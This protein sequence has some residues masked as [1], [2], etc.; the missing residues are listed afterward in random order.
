MCTKRQREKAGRWY[1]R[2]FDIS[3]HSL[4]KHT[5]LVLQQRDLHQQ[6]HTHL[7]VHVNT[8][9]HE[10]LINLAGSF[11]KNQLQ[12]MTK[13]SFIYFYTKI[14]IKTIFWTEACRASWL[15]SLEKNKLVFSIQSIL[16]SLKLHNM[17]A[18]A[19]IPQLSQ[20]LWICSGLQA[21]SI[22]AKPTKTKALLLPLYRQHKL[23]NELGRKTRTGSVS[24][25]I[26]PQFLGSSG[27]EIVQVLHSY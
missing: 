4:R 23:V 10:Q 24:S 19:G 27:E 16:V 20:K 8:S 12:G 18:V 7:I 6:M 9:R 11:W 26:L 22:P 14:F 13:M 2:A 3:Q 21:S 5:S 25:K 15:S 17:Y 1:S